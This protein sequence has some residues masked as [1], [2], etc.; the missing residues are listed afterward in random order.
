MSSIT[1]KVLG[2][3]LDNIKSGKVDLASSFFIQPNPRRDVPHL[4]GS[5]ISPFIYS[6]VIQFPLGAM[7]WTTCWR[8]SL[9]VLME[10]ESG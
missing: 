5:K 3:I 2:R 9:S 6:V 4:A 10:H 1:L 8:E 7:H